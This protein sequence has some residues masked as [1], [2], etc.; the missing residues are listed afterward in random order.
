M[1]RNR[2]FAFLL[3]SC[4]FAPAFAAAAPVRTTLAKAALAGDLVEVPGTSEK[5]EL[6]NM[7]T[8][9]AAGLLRVGLD[10]EVAVPGWPVAPGERA[11]VVLTRRDVYAPEAVIWEVTE[12][13]MRR[14]PRSSL[15]FLWGKAEGAA[16]VR[17]MV[18]VD[19]ET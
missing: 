11:D 7:N 13:G 16:D 2:A 15:V 9:L 17:V 14:L 6:V 5:A 10:Q 12:T 8:S 19:P 3:V 18:S 1:K 4:A